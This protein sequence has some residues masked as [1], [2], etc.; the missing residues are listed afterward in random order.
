MFPAPPHP[1]THPSYNH[2]Q[3]NEYLVEKDNGAAWTALVGG[4]AICFAGGL[5]GA[6][7]EGGALGVGFFPKE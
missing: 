1:P 3:I 5:V 7:V 4:T 2:L 6:W